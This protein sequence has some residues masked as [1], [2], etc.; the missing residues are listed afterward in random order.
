MSAI[1]RRVPKEV[2]AHIIGY[3]GIPEGSLCPPGFESVGQ[4]CQTLVEAPPL[5]AC[6]DGGTFDPAE[7]MC[8]VRE[9]RGVLYRCREG[10]RLLMNEKER[11]AQCV[12]LHHQPGGATSNICGE[13]Y[14]LQIAEGVG[15]CLLVDSG[16][17]LASL[18]RETDSS[19][20]FP[21][22]SFAHHEHAEQA[23]ELSCPPM[24][25]PTCQ[26]GFSW[27]P[28]ALLGPVGCTAPLVS[29]P[30]ASCPGGFA[31]DATLYS[32]YALLSKSDVICAKISLK[33]AAFLCPAGFV[34]VPQGPPESSPPSSSRRRRLGLLDRWRERERRASEEEEE[35]E[36]ER[37]Q[38]ESLEGGVKSLSSSEISALQMQQ[39]EAEAEGEEVQQ[40]R[41][42]EGEETDPTPGP[43]DPPP[44][45]EPDPI[46]QSTSTITDPG[47][48]GGPES[49]SRFISVAASF[50]S[51]GEFIRNAAKAAGLVDPDEE[52]EEEEEQAPTEAPAEEEVLPNPIFL[53]AVLDELPP[54]IF[55]LVA[56]A[57]L[58]AIES[59]LGEI[60]DQ[61]DLEE[62][63]LDGVELTAADLAEL[64]LDLV[65]DIIFSVS[66]EVA[67]VLATLISPER[68]E[69]LG[70]AP[71]TEALPPED[72]D[73]GQQENPAPVPPRCVMT[74]AVPLAECGYDWLGRSECKNKYVIKYIRYLQIKQDVP[75]DWRDYR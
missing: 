45:R 37:E 75:L 24:V 72:V 27:N 60:G 40:E 43:K 61:V 19:L 29:P 16:K 4:L 36:R 33:P 69:E 32:P 3:Q 6:P 10:F 7:A 14:A 64:P 34:T 50:E 25:P 17:C 53:G 68:L 13:G 42:E 15:R 9:E 38:S 5:A 20:S 67:I 62:G 63:E 55:G 46:F 54:E 70:L 12:G 1:E 39:A 48:V 41:R 52:G 8:V 71:P 28:D 31:F 2:K 59:R 26:E 51:V 11:V 22:D 44:E 23:E 47:L 74:V 30:V 21:V 66:L 57:L 49:G 73:A 18:L 58:D 35:E 65:A 56:P